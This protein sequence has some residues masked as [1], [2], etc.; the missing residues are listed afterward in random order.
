MAHTKDHPSDLHPEFLSNNSMDPWVDV[1]S[2]PRKVMFAGHLPQALVISGSEERYW[3]TGT[4]AR[5]G[6]Y[7]F[8]MKAPVS[9]THLTLPTNREV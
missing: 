1:N 7:N 8:A 2:S 6:E 3:Q 9:Y 4:E 5:F